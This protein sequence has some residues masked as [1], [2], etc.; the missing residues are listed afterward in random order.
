MTTET[1]RPPGRPFSGGSTPV[2]TIRVSQ[3]E[4]DL[5]ARAAAAEDMTTS[6]WLRHLAL[7]AAKK[8]GLAPLTDP[9]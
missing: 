4:W 3:E 7:R 1:K 8:A 2:R 5:F 6:A 9:R